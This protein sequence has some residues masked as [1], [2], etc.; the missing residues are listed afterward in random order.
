MLCT[1]ESMVVV[2]CS[3]FQGILYMGLMRFS[4]VWICFSGSSLAFYSAIA[5]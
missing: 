1:S 2:C 5:N 3:L 4:E